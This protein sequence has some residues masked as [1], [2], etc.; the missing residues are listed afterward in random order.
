MGSI[1]E[2]FE[3]I[4][5]LNT[6]NAEL[7]ATLNHHNDEQLDMVTARLRSGLGSVKV[8][9]MNVMA[10][11]KS[12]LRRMHKVINTVPTDGFNSDIASVPRGPMCATQVTLNP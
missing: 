8:D 11:M 3:R 9:I 5:R 1:E 7:I 12:A 6:E 2:I 4:K 10:E